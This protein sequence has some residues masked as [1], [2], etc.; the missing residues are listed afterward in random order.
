VGRRFLDDIS[1]TFELAWYT[2]PWI[3]IAINGTVAPGR[4]EH[5]GD[6]PWLQAIKRL[7]LADHDG[8]RTIRL[9]GAACAEC[10][11]CKYDVR[12]EV[13]GRYVRWTLVEDPGQT[14]VFDRSTYREK[15]DQ[16]LADWYYYEPEERRLARLLIDH[17]PWDG[18]EQMGLDLVSVTMFRGE[19][20]VGFVDEFWKSNVYVKFP[21]RAEHTHD[22]LRAASQAIAVWDVSF[23]NVTWRPWRDPSAKPPY[24]SNWEQGGPLSTGPAIDAVGRV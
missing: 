19:L 21:W 15:L 17:T 14:W 5:V 11:C 10:E 2:G 3:S 23:L 1:F 22:S 4:Y 9:S 13:A 7:S 12:C 8:E 16:A 20:T 6:F 24:P 18:P